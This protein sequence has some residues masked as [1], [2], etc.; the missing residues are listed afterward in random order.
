M[1]ASLTTMHIQPT[2]NRFNFLLLVLVCLP[3]IL[4]R[5]LEKKLV[6]G[7]RTVLFD[8]FLLFFPASGKTLSP[9]LALV[10][11]N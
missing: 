2:I 10:C 1:I 3:N 11:H 8:R 5:K 4:M 7:S 9:V 6:L